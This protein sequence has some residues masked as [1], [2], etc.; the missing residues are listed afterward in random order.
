MTAGLVLGIIFFV[1]II[2]DIPIAISLGLSSIAVIL[3]FDLMPLSGVSSVFFGTLEKF[4]LLA[5]PFFVYSGFVME[6]G[7]I[8]QKLIDLVNGIIGKVTGG[9]A[10]VVIVVGVLLAGISGS[11]PADVAALGAVLIPSMTKLRYDKAFSCGLISV[12]GSLGIVVPPSIAFIVYGIVS[13]T[14]VV[15]LFIA[16]IVPGVLSGIALA[17]PTYLISRKRGYSGEDRVSGQ[18][19]AKRF[20]DA[21]W[22]LL[23]PLFILLGLYFGIFT[24]TELS[25]VLAIYVTFVTLVIYKNIK[26][27]NILKISADSA[28]LSGT[29]LLIIGSASLFSWV[30]TTQGIA[31]RIGEWILAFSS[32]STLFLIIISIILLIAGCFLETNAIIFMFTPIILPIALQLRI[33]PIYLGALMIVNLAIGQSTP[34]LGVNLF[35]ASGLSGL[36][37]ETIAYAALPFILSIIA[38][39]T[40]M[41]FFPGPIMWFPRWLYGN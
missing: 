23:A 11:G 38:V 32:S 40:F 15:K 20:K 30:L 26:P 2:L 37:M 10:Y 18:E 36:K 31:A 8:S 35:V 25:A 6:K 1:L 29:V 39:M 28:M 9:L 3:F 21:I 41:V 4:P 5:I 17:L 14:S 33:D 19:I 12:V 34:P 24:A 7:N 22:G 27:K 13:N 16:G